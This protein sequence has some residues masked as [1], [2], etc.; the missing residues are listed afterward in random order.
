MYDATCGDEKVR[1]F[2]QEANPE[3][4]RAIAR[5]FTEAA[6]RGFWVSRRNSSA[7]RLAEML[8]ESA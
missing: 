8:D 3:A 4:A 2:L 6:R 1:A 7:A 5:R